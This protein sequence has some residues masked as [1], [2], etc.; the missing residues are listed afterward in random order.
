MNKAK[1]KATTKAKTKAETAE[2]GSLV[3]P[4]TPRGSSTRNKILAYFLANID[5]VLDR[6]EIQKASSNARE[7]ERRTEELRDELGYQ[8]HTNKDE[9][10]VLNDGEYILRTDR[11]LPAFTKGISRETQEWVLEHS[12]YTCQMCGYGASDEDPFDRGHKVRLT[13]RHM[14]DKS[15]GGDDSPQNLRTVCTNCDDGLRHLSPRKPDLI[16]LKSMIRRASAD[17]QQEILKLLL[18]KFKESQS[19]SVKF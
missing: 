12:E 14:N 13:V 9:P 10:T 17:D 19:L 18:S 15:P 2:A 7:W 1:S 5:R 8:I 11:R 3:L 4:K 6:E 16:R